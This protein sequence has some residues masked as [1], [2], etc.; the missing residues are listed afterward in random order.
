MLNLNGYTLDEQLSMGHTA[1]IFRGTRHSDRAR[2][3]VKALSM[4]FPTPLQVARLQH[5][6]EIVSGLNHA[7]IIKVHGTEK[8]SH[9]LA[10]VMEDFGGITLR[11]YLSEHTPGLGGKLRIARRIA[12]ILGEI[13]FN[14]IIHKDVNPNNIL[15]NPI[16]GEIK[17]IDFGYATRIVYDSRQQNSPMLLEGTLPYIAPEQTGRMNRPVDYRSD[18]YSLG[19]TLH[20]LLLGRRPFESADNMEL[21]HQHIAVAPPLLHSLDASIPLS[22]SRIVAKLIEKNA[23]NRYQSI[24]G[25]VGDLD[26]CIAAIES[27]QPLTDFKPG[28]HEVTD[29]F[30]LPA[31]LY[32]REA[33]IG[34]LLNAYARACDGRPGL[35]LVTGHSG[36]GKSSLINEIHKP[37]TRSKGLFASGKFDQFRRNIPYSALI[38]AFQSLLRQ[39]LTESDERIAQYRERLLAALGDNAGVIIEVIPELEYILGPQSAVPPLGPHEAQNRFNLYFVN[40]VRVFAQPEHPLALF[41]DDLQWADIPSLNLLELLGADNGC[42]HLL[43]IGAYRH[44]EVSDGHPLPQAIERIRKS[45]AVLSWIELERLP[46]EDIVE[47]VADTLNSPMEKARPLAQLVYRKTVGNPFFLHQLLKSLHEDGLIAYDYQNREWA[48]DILR[49]DRVGITDNVVMLMAD[50]IRKLPAATQHMLK[51]AACIGNQFTLRDLSVVGEAAPAAVASDFRAALGAGLVIPIGDEYKLYGT[52]SPSEMPDGLEVRYRFLHD[53]VQ[54]AAYD[55]LGED[56]K[57]LAHYKAG[58]LLLKNTSDDNLDER[59][60]DI[61]NHFNLALDRVTDNALHLRLAELNLRAA[62]K[63][64]NAIAY[65]PALRYAEAAQTL[66]ADQQEP[67]LAFRI[68][69]E[70]AECEHL[71]GNSKAAEVHYREA[72]D[73][74]TDDGDKS[75]AYEAI[76]HFHTNTGNYRQ[77]Y[78]TGREALRLFGVSLPANFVPPLLLADLVKLKWR[79]RGRKVADLLDLP[80]CS[81]D[82]HRTAM[83]LIGALLK[84]AYQIRPELCVANAVKAVNLSLKHGTMDDN[85][86]AYLV[87]GGIFLG[88]VVGRHKAGYEF[89]Q[90]ALAM[91]ERFNNLKQRSEINFVSGYFTHFWLKPAHLTETY[92]RAAYDSGMQTGDFFHLSCAACTMIE[93]Q[94]LRGVALPEVKRLGREYLTFLQRIGSTEH[95]GA[96]TATLRAIASLEGQTDGPDSFGDAQFDETEFV[97]QLQQYTLKHFAHFYFVNRMK[98]L[99]LWRR[100]KDALEAARQS[101]SYLKHSIA[102]LHTVEHH[103]LHALILCAAFEEDGDRAHL[104]KARKLLKKFDHWSAL[105]PDNFLHK[106]LLIRAEIER[107]TLPDTDKA[108]K[109]YHE[110]INSAGEHGFMQYKAL[111]HELAGRFFAKKNNEMSARGHLREAHYGYLLWGATGIVSKLEYDFPQYLVQHTHDDMTWTAEHNLLRTT[112]SSSSSSSQGNANLDLAT[113]VKA[114]QAISGEIRL[115]D[116]LMKMM[117]IIIENAGATGGAFIRLDEGRLFVE[118]IGSAEDGIALSHGT[119]LSGTEMPLPVV[120]YVARTGECL[121]LNNAQTDERFYGDPYIVAAKPQSLL[122]APVLYQGKPIGVLYLEN[123]LASSAFTSAR[124][125]MLSILSAQAAISIENSR[126]YANL[127]QRVKERTEELSFANE[128]LKNANTEL[129]KLTLTDSLTH[130]SNKRHF[131]QVYDEEWKR[132]MRSGAPLCLMVIDIDCFKLYND[133]Y[134]HLEGD[135][136]LKAVADA[137]NRGVSRASD[138]LARFGGEE[139]VILLPETNIEDAALIAARQVESIRALGIPHKASTATDIVTISLGLAQTVPQQGCDPL[140]LL[141]AA[142]QALYRAKT[143]GRNRYS[144]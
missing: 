83:R 18:Y 41:L 3:I 30:A 52:D 112:S 67:R 134:G 127:E 21:V 31:K 4:E 72:L 24:A 73:A 28:L 135:R 50:A 143:S 77:A 118:A 107:L 142:D 58:S 110:A 69:L 19:I 64:K 80:I 103:F 125:E 96:I 29:R 2:V 93:S 97:F 48:W 115:S 32:G 128:L 99:Y 89:G 49:I 17:F 86:V 14:G 79:M 116:L 60:F 61:L 57:K 122:C 109:H 70:R 138:L 1:F 23:E 34:L 51:L 130:V 74:A 43:M 47:L 102:M 101:E 25:I 63:A 124:L 55:L 137:L 10:I 68:L 141:T 6:H 12:E 65:E 94:F 42:A 54:Q 81:D 66:L 71:S 144:L 84:A 90:L 133:T 87:F 5:E 40:F 15:I 104:R 13:H 46:Q 78:D 120:Q 119:Q 39:V 111:G 132:G 44:N 26:E 20:E 136:C 121:V 33:E 88:G 140:D 95:A 117:G 37:I 113:I 105:N 53:R 22:V 139:F 62:I 123:N 76:I 27:G 106:A 8:L 75:A 35:V 7:G 16:T 98:A 92:Y 114:M 129:E 11:Q 131:Q 126:L 45:G 108:A 91:N 9:S 56:E 100:T 36:I 38:Q 59:L 82:R 85:A